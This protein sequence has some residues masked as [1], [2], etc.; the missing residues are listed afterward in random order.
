MDNNL[1]TALFTGVFVALINILV[2]VF[3]PIESKLM[4][5]SISVFAIALGWSIGRKLYSREKP[6]QTTT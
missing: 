1:K 4:T 5:T 6:Q 3:L 2:E